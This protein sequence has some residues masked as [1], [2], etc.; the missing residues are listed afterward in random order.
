MGVFGVVTFTL[1]RRN[2]EI[3]VRKVL[4]ANAGSIIQLF[5]K[6]YG[7]TIF[8]ANVIAWP[9]A[10]IIINNWLQTYNYRIEQNF[11]S[12]FLVFVLVF[13]FAFVMITAQCFKIAV[14]NP[15]GALRSE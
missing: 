6:E 13:C 1:T 5:L 15:V 8:I 2:K 4:G 14:T 9:V 10:Y 7:L 3:A 12:Y 11:F